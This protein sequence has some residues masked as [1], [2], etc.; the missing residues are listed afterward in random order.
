MHTYI[1]MHTSKTNFPESQTHLRLLHMPVT[2]SWLVHRFVGIIQAHYTTPIAQN[3]KQ[4][5][6]IFWKLEAYTFLPILSILLPQ[7]LWPWETKK[8]KSYLP[9]KIAF[10]S[11]RNY[12]TLMFIS[13][14]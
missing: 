5:P 14:L 4:T 8:K 3:I 1:L 13:V 2:L 7:H 12:K 9:V 11:H 6:D 10:S